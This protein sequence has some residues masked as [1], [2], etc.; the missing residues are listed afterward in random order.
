MQHDHILK[1]TNFIFILGDFWPQGQNLKI[2]FL[3]WS[4]GGPFVQWCETICA[5]LIMGIMR[6]N[7]VKLF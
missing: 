5:I 4:S 1:K 2:I 3:I 6:K 7:S